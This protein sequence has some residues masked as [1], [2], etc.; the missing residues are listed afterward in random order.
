MF[1]ES[2]L[3]P[4]N[5]GGG[6]F[7]PEGDFQKLVDPAQHRPRLGGEGCV[8]AP[9]AARTSAWSPPSLLPL[10]RRPGWRPH[11]P[12]PSRAD[13]PSEKRHCPAVPLPSSPGRPLLSSVP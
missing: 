5:W 4:R 2:S 1:E 10:L 11:T 8:H 12:P 3:E 13:R 9:A 6:T 7:D